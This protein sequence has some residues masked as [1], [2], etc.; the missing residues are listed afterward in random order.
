MALEITPEQRRQ[1]DEF[2]KLYD[3][4]VADVTT[5]IVVQN[6]SRDE[7]SRSV[8]PAKPDSDCQL[9]EILAY[10]EK[11]HREDLRDLEGERTSTVV[12]TLLHRMRETIERL[13]SEAP[14]YA[15]SPDGKVEMAEWKSRPLA[16][17]N[18]PALTTPPGSLGTVIHDPN[19][20]RR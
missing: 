5:G 4:P 7:M 17:H 12:M 2:R 18:G 16:I 1:L 10:L 20:G 19:G 6:P 14:L 11:H 3:E 8:A 9:Y 13:S 15:V